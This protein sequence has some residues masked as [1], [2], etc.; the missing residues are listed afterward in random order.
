M[1]DAR[2]IRP[3]DSPVTDGEDKKIPPPPGKGGF[4]LAGL[5]ALGLLAYGGYGH[6]QRAARAESTRARQMEFVP[7]VRTEEAKRLD[8]PIELTLPGQT[9]PFATARIYP[10]A[11]GY[12]A[13][14]H[15]DLG[16]R[17]KKG[18]VLLRIAAPDLDQQLA[19]AEAQL[20]QL[21]AQLLRAR[22]M[23]DQA[24]ANANLAQA[25]NSRT[26]TLAGQGWAS[27]QNADNTQAGVLAQQANLAS[28]EADVKV[29]QANIKAQ[30]ATVGRLKALTGFEVVTAPF[31]GVVTTRNVDVGDLVQADAGSGTPLLS[32]DR[33]DV[34]RISVNVPQNA[35]VGVQPGVKA[36]IKVPQMPDRSFSGVVE[37][38]SV[39]LLASSRT[40]TTQVDVPNP[41]RTLR[42][43]LYVYVTLAI[44]RTGGATVAV[45]AEAL[46][47]NQ[48]GTR[49]AVAREDDRVNWVEV[50]VARDKGT[51]VEV[52]K[53]LSGGER[54]VLS[55]P[56]DL[57]D[58]GRIAPQAPK[59]DKPMQAA[60]R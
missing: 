38:S 46:V 24:K 28:A 40:L 52:D 21:E 48:S 41:D 32:M 2:P 53:G 4:A 55:P 34:L 22:A 33:D 59:S 30:Q 54:L 35:A 60:Q 31:D 9:E 45:P 6:W 1:S 51:V 50:H 58:G 18:D 23:V 10:R 14:R 37:R 7:K 16:S 36:Q 8:G 42:P 25:T 26:S 20:G 39:A 27:K 15:V 17:V 43:G 5:I 12:I 11:T 44:P 49:V 56:A 47:F 3:E 19:Q 57:K 29:A 13:E